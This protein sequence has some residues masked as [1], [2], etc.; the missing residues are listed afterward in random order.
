MK[1]DEAA[2]FYLT[3]AATA[4]SAER[5][6]FLATG[7]TAGP[8]SPDAQ[9]GGPPA[10]LLGRALEALEPD[11]DRVLGRVT[12]ELLGPVP[13]GP[14]SMTAEVARPGRSVSLRTAVLYAAARD[15]PAARAHGWALPAA[16]GRAAAAPLPQPVPL[17]HTPADGREQDPPPS[18]S[19]GYLDAMEWRWIEGSVGAPG[20]AVV[21][22]RQR[23]PL[24][25]GEQPSPWQRLLC[26]VDS[27]SG[28]SAVLD[29][30]TWAFLNTEL[31]VHV[32]R[33]PVG[34]WVCLVAETRLG[35]GAVG[36]AAADLHDECGWF[37]R[38]AQT[39][40]V[41]PAS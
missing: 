4:G 34:E 22:M 21:W 20:P 30:A 31:S 24:V 33:P 27:A 1:S 29:P 13:V 7:A 26:C 6:S 40:L 36:L 8:W 18:W 41:A 3:R 25:V 11:L 35:G 17:P 16:A 37:G 38:S 28:A 9:H 15:R 23:L 39:L 12:M 19:R 32:V 2:A 5:D 10:A 14:V